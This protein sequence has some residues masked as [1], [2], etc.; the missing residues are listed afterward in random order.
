[1]RSTTQKGFDTKKSSLFLEED[2]SEK[3]NNLLVSENATMNSNNN[4]L[5]KKKKKA[6]AWG[7]QSEGV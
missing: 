6:Y 7:T 2:C 5:S 1:V 4:D 3:V